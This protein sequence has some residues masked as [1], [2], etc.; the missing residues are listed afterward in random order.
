MDKD[1]EFPGFPIIRIG[2]LFI[3][4]INVVKMFY[5]SEKFIAIFY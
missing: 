1:L 2:I 4:Q 3:R 5:L